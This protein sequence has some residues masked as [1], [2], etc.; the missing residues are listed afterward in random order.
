MAPLPLPEMVGANTTLD[1][2]PPNIIDEPRLVLQ[3]V[4]VVCNGRQ[5]KPELLSDELA[6]L[7]VIVIPTEPFDVWS[8][9]DQVDVNRAVAKRRPLDH[10]PASERLGK[11]DLN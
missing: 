3:V 8:V 1:L 5:I 2:V 9:S 10:G 11:V 4:K 6:N 7:R